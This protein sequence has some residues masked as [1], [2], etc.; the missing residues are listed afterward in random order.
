MVEKTPGSE[1]ATFDASSSKFPVLHSQGGE[2]SVA[3]IIED[4]FGDEGFS[5]SDLDRLKVPSGGGQAWDIPDEDPQRFV[6]GIIIHRQ[7]TRSFWFAGRGEGGQE[8]TPPDCWSGDAKVGTGVFGPGSQSNPTG[9]C[10]E[11]PMNVFGSSDR[12]SGNG[13]A[14]KEQMQIFMLQ[15]G[16]ILP[17]QV[18]LPPTSLRGFRKYMTRLASKGKSYYSVVTRLGLEKVKGGGQEYSVVE[19]SKAADLDPAEALAARSFG[20][21]IRSYLDQA[22]AAR[23]AAGDGAEEGGGPTGVLKPLDTPEAQA[24]AAAA[25]QAGAKA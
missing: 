23:A 3:Q 7:P 22:A 8:D 19:P 18:S 13:K 25:A 17:V 9:E 12:G 21:T 15:E 6:E 1:L 20:E 11:C 10:G 2:G 24:A 16:S 4:N 14:C 5:P